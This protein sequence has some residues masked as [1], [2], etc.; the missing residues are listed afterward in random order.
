MDYGIIKNCDAM[1]GV[2]LPAGHDMSGGSNEKMG[3]FFLFLD[4]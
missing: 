2:G 4:L 3:I 1:G